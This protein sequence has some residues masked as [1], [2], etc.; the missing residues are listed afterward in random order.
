[1]KTILTSA[2]AKQDMHASFETFYR[3]YRFVKFVTN[4]TR[5]T[6]GSKMAQIK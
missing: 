2:P 4:S 6:L 3:T 1:M 5:S